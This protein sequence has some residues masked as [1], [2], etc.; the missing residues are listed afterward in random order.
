MKPE[1]PKKEEKPNDGDNMFNF[2]KKVNIAVQDINAEKP[3]QPKKNI[4]A[5]PNS[6]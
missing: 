4:I 2:V 3:P 6:Q 5:V 1:T